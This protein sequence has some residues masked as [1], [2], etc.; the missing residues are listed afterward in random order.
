MGQFKKSEKNTKSLGY[1]SSFRQM[2]WLTEIKFVQNPYIGNFWGFWRETTPFC[3][4][5]VCR[6]QMTREGKSNVDIV[7]FIFLKDKN[8]SA[9]I[10]NFKGK[11]LIF[12]SF[13]SI[14]NSWVFVFYHVCFFFVRNNSAQS[15]TYARPLS[16]LSQSL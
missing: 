9:L 8:Y 4:T 1:V 6:R 5:L 10:N 14:F 13:S 2:P 12:V 3:G 16:P 11:N 15:C 7:L